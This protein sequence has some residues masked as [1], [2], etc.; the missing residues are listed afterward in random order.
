VCA[1]GEPER[2]PNA[3]AETDQ[4]AHRPEE[5]DHGHAAL[6]SKFETSAQSMMA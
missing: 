6:A 1:S 5:K 4:A 3:E 2:Q